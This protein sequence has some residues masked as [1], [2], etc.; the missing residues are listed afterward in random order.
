MSVYSARW[1]R[2]F[3]IA[4]QERRLSAKLPVEAGLTARVA[5]S[6]YEFEA[7]APSRHPRKSNSNKMRKAKLSGTPHSQRACAAASPAARFGRERTRGLR[8]SQPISVFHGVV[9]SGNL[10]F[11]RS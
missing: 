5:D 1:S 3:G 6:A 7:I 8:G 11:V 9:T 10:A 4:P 2:R